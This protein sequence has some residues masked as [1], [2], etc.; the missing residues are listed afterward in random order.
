MAERE[1]YDRCPGEIEGFDLVTI[2][3]SDEDEA[4]YKIS[5]LLI[6]DRVAMT[7]LAGKVEVC[8]VEGLTNG[9]YEMVQCIAPL[10]HI[11]ENAKC[12]PEVCKN[13]KNLSLFEFV[14]GIKDSICW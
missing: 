5:G 10:F 12:R 8:F 1:L 7:I 13:L 14:G 11:G 6:T 4:D 9:E 2:V 3:W